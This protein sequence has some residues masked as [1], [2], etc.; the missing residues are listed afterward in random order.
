MRR[1]VS[2]ILVGG[3]VLGAV[4]LAALALVLFGSMNPLSPAS[5]VAVYIDE[6]VSGLEEGAAVKLRGVKV[7]QVA[8]LEVVCDLDAA[9]TVVIVR[10]SISPGVIMDASGQ[11]LD[12]GDAAALD[13]LI[14][15]GL[16]AKVALAGV[17][18]LRYLDLDFYE[19]GD[20]PARYPGGLDQLADTS[21][22]IPAIPSTISELTDGLAG[23]IAD[24]RRADISGA[25][26]KFSQALGASEG[27]MTSITELARKVARFL[28]EFEDTDIRGL[29]Q[30]L[31]RTLEEAEAGLRSVTDA[32]EQVAW[33]IGGESGLDRAFINTLEAIEGAARAIEQFAAYLE[34]YPD[35]LLLGKPHD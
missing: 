22:V 10:C 1:D 32:S 17:T 6:S 29:V 8:S 23:I 33:L 18:G 7:G 5:R 3:L 12:L 4:V 31:S 28:S 34:R 25:T 35:A 14:E 15:S 21:L 30:R 2:A 11:T 27:T 16:R 24:L 13:R 20:H 9:L 26:A 19:P